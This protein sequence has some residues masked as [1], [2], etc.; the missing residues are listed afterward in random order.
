MLAP[1]TSM[2]LSGLYWREQQRRAR[3]LR[4]LLRDIDTQAHAM[5]TAEVAVASNYPR[6]FL[7]ATIV[8]ADPLVV[9]TPAFPPDIVQPG[10]GAAIEVLDYSVVLLFLLLLS[11]LALTIELRL[12]MGWT[13]RLAKGWISTT[14]TM[15][16]TTAEVQ[17]M[18]VLP[19]PQTQ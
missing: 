17:T 5:A 9:D 11:P 4:G 8:D 2:E 13:L 16:G 15:M 6:D 1:D 19:A 7:S 12:T 14:T 18:L 3:N 10:G